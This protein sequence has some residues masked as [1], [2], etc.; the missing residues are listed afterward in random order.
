MLVKI[1]NLFERLRR[2]RTLWVEDLPSTPSRN[3]IYIVGGR[4]Y[5][6]YAAMVCP[7]KGCSRLIQLEISPEFKKRWFVKEHHDGTLTLSPSI[8]INKSKCKCHYWIRKGY[9]VWTESPSCLVPKENRRS[10]HTLIN[11]SRTPASHE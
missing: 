11:N 3:T 5:P 9:V 10:N 2:Y 4:L 7:R 6:Y 1:R 8:Y